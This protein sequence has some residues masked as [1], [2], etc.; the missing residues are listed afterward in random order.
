MCKKTQADGILK[1]R[2]MSTWR[3][4][5]N[6]AANREKPHAA[7]A[8]VSPNERYTEMCACIP[9]PN[10]HLPSGLPKAHMSLG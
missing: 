10:L 6:Q 7:L 1:D 4:G 9:A 8:F 2:T 3:R 5:D